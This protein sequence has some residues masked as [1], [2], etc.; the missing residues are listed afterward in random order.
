MA[1]E[2]GRARESKMV[3]KGEKREGRMEGKRRMGEGRKKAKE[4]WPLP[5]S[6]FQRQTY[7]YPVLSMTEA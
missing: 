2:N 5:P 7:C 6:I 1:E 4:S 3:R